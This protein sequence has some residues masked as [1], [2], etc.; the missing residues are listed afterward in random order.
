MSDKKI[1]DLP[2]DGDN[3]AEDELWTSLGEMGGTANA[4]PSARLRQEFYSKLERASRPTLSEKLRDLLGFSG[5]AG[6]L[7][8]AACALLGLGAGQLF[9]YTDSAGGQRLAA[10]EENVSALN[11]SL[12]LDRLEN[13]TASKRLRGVIDAAYV[14]GDDAEIARALLQRATE[15]RVYSVRS[16]AIDALGSQLNAPLVGEQLMDLLQRSEAPLVQ[17]ALVDLVLRNGSEQQV[18]ELLRLA[19]S[20]RLHPDLTRHVL[21]SL[22]RD[23]V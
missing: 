1:S 10:L 11:R 15:D 13:E 4:E 16:A 8:A 20:G 3:A 6:W 18:T 9:V 14:V 19:E 7:T 17:F 12:I 5:N 22:Q 23:V 21:T 2:F